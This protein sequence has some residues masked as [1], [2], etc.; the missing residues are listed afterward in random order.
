MISFLKSYNKK[1]KI[2]RPKIGYRFIDINKKGCKRNLDNHK[3][4]I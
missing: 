1:I 2:L 3:E 4:K